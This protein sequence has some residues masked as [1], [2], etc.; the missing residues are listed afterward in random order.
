MSP[1][2]TPVQLA[3]FSLPVMVFQGIEIAWRTYLPAFLA[4]TVGLSLATIGGLL[5][6][7]RLFDVAAAPVIGWASDRI[8]GSFGA[9]RTWLLLGAPLVSVGALGLFRAP[10]GS[11]SL[12]ILL[13]AFTLHLGYALM[14]TPHGGW[15]L[16]I[17][18]DAQE[19][20]RIQGAKIWLAALAGGL[21]LLTLATAE[22]G[23]AASPADQLGLLAT[24]IAVSAPLATL[25]LASVVRE[26]P[27]RIVPASV[28]PIRQLSVILRDPRVVTVMSLY[29]LTGLAE[30]ASGAVLIF[31]IEDGLA[32]HGWMSSLAFVQYPMML[33]VVPVWL[34]WSSRC[35]RRQVL[36]AV[37]AW[38]MMVAIVGFAVPMAMPAA[39][40]AFLILRYATGSTELILLRAITADG[41]A[42]DAEAGRRTAASSYALFNLV[43]FGAMGVG[44]AGIMASLSAF[45][46]GEGVVM[47][48]QQ[49]AIRL[50]FLLPTILT[51]SIGVMLL[52]SRKVCSLIR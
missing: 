35:G 36:L 17:G 41:V 40:A 10:P 12:I 13:W 26:P 14:L 8:I 30:G 29:A 6:L 5:L 3:V 9:R 20:T 28:A 34:R 23:Y 19:R 47:P 50:A 16:E 49:F 22:R 39:A 45:G 15:G 46:Y 37:Y 24:I 32:L 7:A 38:Q 1:R 44:G 4:R 25:L 31:F 2:L 43:L 48:Q 18:I 33:M 11:S 21:I 42:R 27:F 52:L 51:G